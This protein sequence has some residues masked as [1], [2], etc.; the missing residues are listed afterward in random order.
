MVQAA[1]LVPWRRRKD[2]ALALPV[3]LALIAGL[4][5]S[6][7]LAENW[8]RQI[9][10]WPLFFV[11]WGLFGLFFTLFA[12]TC[13]RLV[14]L[15][16]RPLGRIALPRWS[17][18][19]SW[20][21]LRLVG[22]WGIYLAVWW[23]CLLLGANAWPRAAGD[24]SEWLKA[25]ETAGKVPALYVIARLSLVFPATA[26][27]RPASFRWAWRASRGNGWRLVVVVTVLPWLVGLLFG[28]LYREDPTMAE[29]VLL[30]VAGTALFAFEIAA[31]SVAYRELTRDDPEQAQQ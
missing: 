9:A 6:W 29:T 26:I 10:G 20:F 23:L 13:H 7:Y 30:T 22:V 1:L 15:Q 31:L 27:D 14:L 2:F 11:Y 18:R 21:F 8:M 19:E 17:W 12:V 4:Y 3:P 5:L 25:I 28:L 16:S 24:V